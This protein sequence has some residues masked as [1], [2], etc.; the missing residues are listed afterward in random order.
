[1]LKFALGVLVGAGI[2]YVGS[3]E[4]RDNLEKARNSFS[5]LM[6][7]KREFNKEMARRI[8]TMREDGTLDDFINGKRR[9]Y[10]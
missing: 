10:Y 9:L 8:I 3:E 4:V 7:D 5:Q 1:M 6:N 2:M